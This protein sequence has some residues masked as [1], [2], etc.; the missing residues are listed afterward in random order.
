VDGSHRAAL[1]D[2][3]RL[4]T[5]VVASRWRGVAQ[6]CEAVAAIRALERAA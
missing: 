3:D 2:L 4:I 1:N 5:R 6:D